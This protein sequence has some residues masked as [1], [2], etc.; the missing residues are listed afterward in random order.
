MVILF[1]TNNINLQWFVQLLIFQMPLTSTS[2]FTDD[3]IKTLFVNRKHVENTCCSR[4]G[5]AMLVGWGGSGAPPGVCR[6]AESITTHP[7]RH[8]H[9]RTRAD[10]TRAGMYTRRRVT[11]PDNNDTYTVCVCNTL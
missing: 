7:R 11:L 4:K 6:T 2:S 8:T 5:A 1:N 9:A 3:A 10:R